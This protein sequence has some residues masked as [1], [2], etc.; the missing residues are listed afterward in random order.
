MPITVN[1]DNTPSVFT[2]NDYAVSPD[3]CALTVSCA[4]PTSTAGPASLPC[5]E[6]SDINDPT[7]QFTGTDYTDGSVPPGDYTFTYDV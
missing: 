6:I 2:Y 5:Q 1:Y 7:W 3:Y 4:S